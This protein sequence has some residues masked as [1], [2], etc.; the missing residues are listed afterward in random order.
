MIVEN[1]LRSPNVGNSN[2]T[3]NVNTD[4]NLNNNNANNGNGMAP[5]WVF[6]RLK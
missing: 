5:D 2:N 4:G 1:W 3:R 6:A